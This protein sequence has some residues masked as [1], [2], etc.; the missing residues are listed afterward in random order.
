VI[1]RLLVVL[2]AGELESATFKVKEDIPEV[3]GVPLIVPAVLNV[4]PADKAPE[5]IDQL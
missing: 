5:E 3:V 1:L 4:K 2:C